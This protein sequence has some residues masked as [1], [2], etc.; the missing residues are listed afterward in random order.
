MTQVSYNA[1]RSLVAGV[2]LGDTVVLVLKIKYAMIIPTREPKIY[3]RASLAGNREGYYYRGEKTWSLETI[4]LSLTNA[5]AMTQFLDSVEDLQ[6]FQF[7]PYTTLSYRY[8]QRELVAYDAKPHP[9][10]K[11]KIIFSFRLIE[12]P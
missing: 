8:V 6:R 1:R 12:V 2:T 4:P 11:D 5:D 3:Q 7:S 10:H 9:S